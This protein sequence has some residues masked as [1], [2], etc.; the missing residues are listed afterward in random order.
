MFKKTTPLILILICLLSSAHAIIIPPSVTQTQY[1]WRNDDGNQ[2]A[3][4]WKAPV[5]TAISVSDTSATLRL[6]LELSRNGAGAFNLNKT[7]EYSANNGT[8]WVPVTAAATNAFRYVSSGFVA[9]GA[10]TTNQLGAV[11]PGTFVAG[12]VVAATP[13]AT[14]ALAANSRTEYEWVIRP[15]SNTLPLTTYIFRSANQGTA[16]TQMAKLNTTC[17]RPSPVINLGPDTTICAG[18]NIIY[19][20]GSFTAYLW[21]DNTLGQ[22]RTGSIPGTY[23]VKV[24]DANGCTASDTVHLAN[25][26]SPVV[27]LG[28]DMNQCVDDG[29]SVTL[30][31]G[32]QSD[33]PVFSWDNGTNGQT[34][35][36]VSS[37]NYI[38]TVTNEFGCR[39]ADTINII[40]RKNPVVALGNDTS[41]C[42]GVTLTLDA[43]PNGTSYFWNTGATTQTTDIS[44]A[45]S[46]I[47]I[48]TNQEG[49]VKSDTIEVSM[50]GELPKIS[51][52]N[53]QNN[54]VSTF[55]FEAVNPEYVTAYNWDFGDNSA[56]STLPAPTHTYAVAGSYS[57]TLRLNSSCGHMT[58]L[59]ST[60]IVG[61]GNTT[62]RSNDILLYPNPAK[63]VLHIISQ[64]GQAVKRIEIYTMGGQMIH[65]KAV[66]IK[67]TYT[68]STGQLAKGIYLFKLTT[69]KEVINQLVEIH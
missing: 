34:R 36:V 67:D 10:A 12:Q 39:D 46:Y 8:T 50:A 29:A 19:D 48:V 55:T 15:T 57:V 13:A 65:S 40:L 43:G 6:R 30:D 60:H 20:P 33:N 16:P 62:T 61:I 49:C 23:F 45:G 4:T 5:N 64:N 58:F 17:L 25:H 44:S 21:D 22:T 28:P 56:P 54:G 47:T 26:P 31:A 63:D 52:I 69:G 35:E 41:V 3:A 37:G 11:T 24:T 2:T 14:V 18:H 38:V 32:V 7:L 51:G 27:D 53:V 66:D 42:N 1:R 68:L 9:D 59:T